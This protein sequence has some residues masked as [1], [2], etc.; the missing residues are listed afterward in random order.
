MNLKP[1]IVSP[2]RFDLQRSFASKDGK[3]K[4]SNLL[5]GFFKRLDENDNKSYAE[6][7]GPGPRIEVDLP[8]H[9]RK[10]SVD[11]PSPRDV[12][13]FSSIDGPEAHSQGYGELKF[14]D[15]LDYFNEV[16]AIQRKLL[17][18]E[19]A[20][21]EIRNCSNCRSPIQYQESEWLDFEHGIPNGAS[22][23]LCVQYECQ[24]AG[25][26]V[27]E[28]TLT[29]LLNCFGSISKCTI[30]HVGFAEVTGLQHGWGVVDFVDPENA[31]LAARAMGQV[32]IAGVSYHCY[33]Y[34]YSMSV[35][36]SN[37]ELVNNTELEDS[38]RMD[39]SNENTVVSIEIPPRLVTC[40]D[41]VDIDVGVGFEQQ[42]KYQ[43]YHQVDWYLTDEEEYPSSLQF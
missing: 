36:V 19:G 28:D 4:V 12:I 17:V 5:G 24:K 33:Y 15:N 41:E 9:K 26:F 6:H 20:C 40:V 30:D 21:N 23:R 14:R 37:A 29:S 42:V 39:L 38:V 27:S 10:S 18:D 8:H 7:D 25:T 2:T 3:P 1:Q 13:T 34:Y 16:L 11:S 22:P 31:V 32:C 43:G 35:T